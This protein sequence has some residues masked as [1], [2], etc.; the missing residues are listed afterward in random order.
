M[1]RRP[2]PERMAM[3]AFRIKQVWILIDP[4]GNE[5]LK[6]DRAAMEQYCVEHRCM[7]VELVPKEPAALERLR[8]FVFVGD[9]D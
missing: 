3:E 6:T 1:V 2:A 9:H 7:P 8:R 5:C 4:H